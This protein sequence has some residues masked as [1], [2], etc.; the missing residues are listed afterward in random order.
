MKLPQHVV[1][2][3]DGNRRW[4]K[5]NNKQ[6]FLGHREGAKTT[7]KILEKALNLNIPYLTFWGCSINNVTKRPLSEANFLFKIFEQYFKKIATDKTI[8]DNNVKIN[9][10]GRW[11]TLFPEKTKN[12]IRKAIK[13]TEKYDHFVLTFLLA[14]SGTDEMI[15]A[16]R[17]I[18]NAKNKTLLIDGELIKNNLWTFNLPPVDLV[19]RTGGEPHWSAGFM[20]WDVAEAVLHFTKTLWPDFSTEEF[21]NVIENYDKTERRFGK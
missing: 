21:E 12:Q 8:R 15:E 19:I 11:E 4:A 3:P 14:Y 2:I 1:I 5:K 13:A 18:S 6:S 10:L 17:K 7:Q 9:V 16:V 20:M